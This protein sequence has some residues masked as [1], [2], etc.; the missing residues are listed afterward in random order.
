M[1]I[2]IIY[3]SNHFY[4]LGGKKS[5]G[6]LNALMYGVAIVLGAYALMFLAGIGISVFIIYKVRKGLKK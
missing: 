2:T 1:V 6:V 5:M 3:C 4:F